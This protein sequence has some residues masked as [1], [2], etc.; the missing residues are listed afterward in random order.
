MPGLIC[1]ASKKTNLQIYGWRHFLFVLSLFSQCAQHMNFL[2]MV[3]P[4]VVR[5]GIGTKNVIESKR[6]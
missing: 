2:V 6:K 5:S 1:C 4:L 3:C